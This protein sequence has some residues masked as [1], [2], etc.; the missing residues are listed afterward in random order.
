[1]RRNNFPGIPFCFNLMMRSSSQSLS[2]AFDLSRNTPRTSYPSSNDT[3]TPYTPYTHILHIYGPHIFTIR[4]LILFNNVSS[5][6]LNIELSLGCHCQERLYQTKNL[7]KSKNFKQELR[8]QT[9]AV[10]NCG[11]LFSKNYLSNSAFFVKSIT[12]LFSKYKGGIIGDFFIQK[13][14]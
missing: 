7:S 11:A 14:F 9:T 12:N 2:I 3:Y 8:R 6:N 5:R 1:M 4:Q 10:I 13:H